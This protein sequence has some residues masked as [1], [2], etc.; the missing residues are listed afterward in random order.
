MIYAGRRSVSCCLISVVCLAFLA[1]PVAATDIEQ[2]QFI[3]FVNGKEA[4][5]SKMTIVQK[6]D[7]TTDMSATVDVKFR[8]VFS[9]YHL[10]ITTQES[11]KDGRLVGMKSSSTENS[12]QTEVVVTLENKQLRMR[13]N[14]QERGANPDAWTSSYWKLADARFHNKQ[15][16][17]LEVDS[18]KEYTGE[19]KFIDNQKLKVAG[20][21]LDCYHFRVTGGPGPTDLWFD[22]YHRLVRQEFTE[23]GHKTIVQLVNIQR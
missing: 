21:L 2:R 6:D 16:P 18:G 20:Q 5:S 10:K 15:V 13:V 1:L 9:D 23:L 12:K 14:G 22:R 17:I 3:I 7:G 11:W 19:L 4:G 8:R